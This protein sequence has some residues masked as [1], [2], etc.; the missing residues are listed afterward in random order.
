MSI[1][2]ETI[3]ST[4]ESL[5]P[6]AVELLARLISFPSTSGEE[7]ELMGWAEEAFRE[8]G[9]EVTRVPLSDT[10]KQDE[11]YSSPIPDLRYDGRFNLRLRLP[12]SGAGRTLLF[13]THTDVV[14]PSQGQEKPFEAVRTEGVIHGRGACDAKGQVATIW[15][16]LAAMVKLDARLAGDVLAH[17]VVE[18]ENGGNGTLAMARAGEKADACIVMEPTAGKI[19]TS[20]RGAVWFRLVCQGKP[21]HSG[22]AGETLS[23]LALARKTMDVLERYHADLLAASRGIPLFDK[24]ENPM[25]ITFGRLAAGDWPATAP[26]RAT[27]EGVLGLLPNKTRHEVMDELRAALAA[28]D[29]MLKERV[30]VEFIYRHDSHV[31]D[32]DHPLAVG[33]KACCGDWELPA[34]IDAMTASCDSWMYNNQLGIP[35][36][37]YGPG[38]LSYAHTNEEQIAV[39]QIA[40]AACVLTDFSL[41]WCG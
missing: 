6:S 22:R 30:R 39:R 26:A 7:H 29:P 40:D 21:G 27:L 38:T 14:P 2:R 5:V 36:V 20:V 18:E 23:A 28:A 19:F 12:G 34:E 41:R 35:T 13:N 37:V 15:L 10:I 1:G 4:V 16:V 24:Y 25:P 8:L 32:P 33:L 31:L 11:D 17:L 3:R 9:V